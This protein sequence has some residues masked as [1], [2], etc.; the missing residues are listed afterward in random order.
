MAFSATP[1]RIRSCPTAD[2]PLSGL[3]S[4]SVTSKLKLALAAPNTLQSAVLKSTVP[5][6][7]GVHFGSRARGWS[8]ANPEYLLTVART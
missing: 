3:G 8:G 7:S 2:W 1:A 4:P 5:F 6:L